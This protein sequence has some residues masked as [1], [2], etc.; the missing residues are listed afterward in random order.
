MHSRARVILFGMRCAFTE[1][2]LIALVNVDN[3]DLRAVVL[4]ER[5]DTASVAD[6]MF[7]TLRAGQIPMIGVADRSGI[8]APEFRAA[9]EAIAPDLIVVACFP[10]RL[11]EWLLAL[12]VRGCLNIHPSLLPDGRGPEPVFWAYRW[13]LV[14]TGVTVHVMD[15]GFDTGPIVAQQRVVIPA[16]ATL[17][18]LEKALA[19]LGARLLIER[20][21]G[22]LDGS[23]VASAQAGEPSRYARLP[24]PDD[25]LVP[26]TWSASR[27]ARFIHAVRQV[28]GP[29]PVLVQG[30]GQ[31]LAVDDVIGEIEHAEVPEP[32]V[33][34]GPEAH[35]RFSP[36]VLLCRL[37]A[38]PQPLRL[39]RN[40][41]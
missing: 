15:A 36:G 27:A 40:P 24:R 28:Y 38:R 37:A 9:L 6:S 3:V 4:P 22:V 35:V 41:G 12:P 5:I 10:W 11:P 8:A 21:P 17:G 19:E 2:A 39:H 16:D 13:G 18:S 32:V 29:V 7:A 20:L 1:P 25:L 14:E 33:I 34:Q 26:T 23:A 31:R 30:T